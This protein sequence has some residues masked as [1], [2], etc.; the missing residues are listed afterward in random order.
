MKSNLSIAAAACAQRAYIRTKKD[1]KYGCL[2]NDDL[3]ELRN[4]AAELARM[5][6]RPVEEITVRVQALEMQLRYINRLKYGKKLHIIK[7][8][9]EIRSEV[10]VLSKTLNR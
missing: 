8:D 4:L 10:A 2:F 1:R 3:R 5:P 7:C 9:E 6:D